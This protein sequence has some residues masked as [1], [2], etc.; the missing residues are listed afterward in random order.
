[1]NKIEDIILKIKEGSILWSDF[2]N[3]INQKELD[4][5]LRHS[6]TLKKKNFGNNLK[7]Y[8]PNKKF[9]AVSITGSYCALNC[10]HCNKKYLS[11]MKGITK[12]E[13]LYCY[14][15][16]LHKREGVGALISGGCDPEGAVPLN[17]YLDVI[18]E[19]KQKTNL[20]INTHTG[21]ISKET[22]EKLGKS[23]VDI[24]S[25]DVNIDE[26]IIKEIYHLDKNV[27]D[28]TRAIEL[29]QRYEI[30]LVPHI[31]IGLYYGTIKKELATIQFIKK[32]IKEPSLIV[33]IALIPPKHSISKFKIPAPEEI[34]KIIAT[35]RVIFPN[36]E[37]SLGCM[38]PRGKIKVKL[39]KLAIKAGINRI[40]IPSRKTLDWVRNFDPKI[41]F[42]FF[43][44][45]CAIPSK[46]EK[47]AKSKLDD[48]RIYQNYT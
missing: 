15:E 28:Y 36:T 41:N 12:Q 43:S 16:D 29:L 47:I 5:F 33:F 40:E 22:A 17:D 34:S 25:F 10:E 44:A 13:D 48:L 38:R 24:V 23:R 39:E 18:K 45:C 14:L 9:P 26:D 27:N 21:L 8:I 20:I 7:I 31:C 37:L 32:S 11:G 3:L 42:Q 4:E 30:N 19:I 46:Y 1:M 35:A 2:D 6:Y